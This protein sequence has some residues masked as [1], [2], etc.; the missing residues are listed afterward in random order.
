[1]HALKKP[2][3]YPTPCGMRCHCSTSSSLDSENVAAGKGYDHVPAGL[4][5][6]RGGRSEMDRD[7][8]SQSRWYD[9]TSLQTV[10]CHIASMVVLIDLLEEKIVSNSLI[11]SQD[12]WVKHFIYIALA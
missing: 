2:E 7:P 6:P 5:Y 3:V 8:E 4:E 12:W 11:D 10:S 1:M 9:M